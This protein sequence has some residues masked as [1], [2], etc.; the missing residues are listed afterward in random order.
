MAKGRLHLLY[1]ANPAAWLIEQA[2]G[3]AIDGVNRILD[4]EL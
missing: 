3:L 4:I 1:E 2:G